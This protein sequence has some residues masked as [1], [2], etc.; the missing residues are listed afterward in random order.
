VASPAY[1]RLKPFLAIVTLAVVAA[2]SADRAGSSPANSP[3]TSAT[4]TT[5][6]LASA[7]V[8]TRFAFDRSRPF[9]IV[10]NSAAVESGVRVRDITYAGAAGEPVEAYLVFP[11]GE[12]PF[13]A[14]LFQHS[15]GASRGEFLPEAQVL[16]GRGVASVLITSPTIDGMQGWSLEAIEAQV[17][18]MSRAMDLLAAQ[19]KVDPTRL[20]F[21]GYSLGAVQGSVF[22]GSEGN[23][24]R[25]SVLM[26]FFPHYGVMGGPGLE[27]YD[28][29]AWLRRTTAASL[30]MQ[31]GTADPY[32]SRAD[33]NEL[34]PAS[35]PN[36]KV[37]WYDADHALNA[38]AQQDR[39]DFLV[40]KLGP[41][42]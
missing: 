1:V 38:Q 23:R 25:A 12:G 32:Y 16:A 35:M 31:L 5:S 24:L 2:C 20:G 11:D 13:G 29:I 33:W 39:L 18:E 14:V 37:D 22:A 7:T 9:G 42:R 6:P 10:E 40:A 34:D 26:A 27:E 30:L 41:A 19:P 3:S 8:D 21:V 15:S 4:T 36:L 28:P 17:R